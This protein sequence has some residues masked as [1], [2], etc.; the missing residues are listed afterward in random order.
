MRSE[1]NETSMTTRSNGAPSSAGSAA[2]MFVRS[3]TVTRAS[4][5]QRPRELPVADV[6]RDDARRA[7][8]GAGSR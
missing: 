3:N 1:M 8:A 2:R 6:D 7:R 4:R 5:A